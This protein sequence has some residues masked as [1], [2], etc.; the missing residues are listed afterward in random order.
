MK[1]FLLVMGSFGWTCTGK[2]A[3]DVPTRAVWF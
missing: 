1:P 2:G 3:Y